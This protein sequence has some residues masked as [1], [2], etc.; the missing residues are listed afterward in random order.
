MQILRLCCAIVVTMILAGCSSHVVTPS[1]ADMARFGMIASNEQD[2]QWQTE[3]DIADVLDKAPL[4][5]FPST[6]AIVR[7]QGAGP[8]SQSSGVSYGRGAY[9]VVLTPTVEKEE[10]IEAIH[11][12]DQVNGAVR[13]NRLVLG[14]NLHSD[15]ELRTAAARL[16]ADLTLIYTINTEWTIDDDPKPLDKITFGFARFRNVTVTS[17]ATALLLGTHNGY[18]YATAEVAKDKRY[19][20]N[21]WNNSE[22][23]E[24]AQELLE[25]QA[26]DGLIQDFVQAWPRVLQQYAPSQGAQR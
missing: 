9:R 7:V 22:Q 4:A 18:V 17:T 2:R 13:L 16:H 21:A 11:E 23:I 1:G 26:F 12:L 5:R 10:H 24:E 25:Q 20:D 6:V 14:S 15:K 19:K 3:S 8:H